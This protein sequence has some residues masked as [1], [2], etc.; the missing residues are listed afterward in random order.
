MSNDAVTREF[1]VK[2]VGLKGKHDVPTVILK[3]A[4]QTEQLKIVFD[5]ESALNDYEIN[6]VLTLKLKHGSAQQTLT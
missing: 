5:S 2:E 4:T 6:D 3:N 1:I